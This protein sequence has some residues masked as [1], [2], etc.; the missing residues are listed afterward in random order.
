M[1]TFN[2]FKILWAAALLLMMNATAV[3]EEK[4]QDL[5]AQARDPTAP[6]IAFA[7]RYDITTSFHNLSDA[8]QQQL[9][10]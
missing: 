4:P 10:I 3:A 1:Q 2:L 9:I 5:A 6:L 8:D 7:I